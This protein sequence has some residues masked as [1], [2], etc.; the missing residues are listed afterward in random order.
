MTARQMQSSKEPVSG[1]LDLGYKPLEV[2]FLTRAN[3]CE[4]SSLRPSETCASLSSP[5]TG[6]HS[7]QMLFAWYTLYSIRWHNL[8]QLC[9]SMLIVL[10]DM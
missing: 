10:S 1:S 3:L 9:G 6:I 7:G 8:R 5:G 4:R 2:V